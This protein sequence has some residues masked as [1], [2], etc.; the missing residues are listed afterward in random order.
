MYK[1]I[2]RLFIIASCG[3]AFQ[4]TNAFHIPPH[5]LYISVVEITHSTA[6]KKALISVKVFS[7]DL[8]DALKNH[9]ETYIPGPLDQFAKMNRPLIEKYFNKYFQCSINKETTGL[10]LKKIEV[11]NDAHFIYFEVVSPA[12]WDEIII[13]APFFMELFPSQSNIITIKNG[14]NTSYLRLTKASPKGVVGF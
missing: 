8:Q 12:I 11:E 5:A 1:F 13:E 2:I 4:Q 6:S 7:D 10:T 9:S 3:F 14:E